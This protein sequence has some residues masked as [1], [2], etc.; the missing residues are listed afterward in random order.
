[1]NRAI[2]GII[3]STQNDKK[4]HGRNF[5]AEKALIEKN[6]Q[7]KRL[8][9]E[10]GIVADIM[11]RSYRE[12][13]WKTKNKIIR[14]IVTLSI[15]TICL[16]FYISN[17]K[18]NDVDLKI[19]YKVDD[20]FRAPIMVTYEKG[21]FGK[22][23]VDVELVPLG[24]GQEMSLAISTGK[25]DVCSKGPTNFFIPISKGAPVKVIAFQ[26]LSRS[27]LFVRPDSGIDTFKDLEGRTVCSD[28]GGSSY[29]TLRNALERENIDIS[30]ITFVDID[31]TY[32]PIA[33]MERRVVDAST[34]A[35]FEET[36]YIEA[37]AVL[38][39]EWRT[40]GY[41]NMFIPKVIIAV[42][43][44]FLADNHDKVERFIDALI[45]GH[46]FIESNPKEAAELVAKHINLGTG[47]ASDFSGEDVQK[48][49]SN[50][51][52]MLWFDPD[53]LVDMSRIAKELGDIENELTLEQI[54]DL[55]FEQK[56]KSAQADIYESKD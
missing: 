17:A 12:S 20:I 40:K 37:G 25:I 44:D 14:G 48:R 6:R 23:G 30:K 36:T 47:G 5:K 7:S 27:L 22:H 55:T 15:I 3:M 19:G 24:G 18:P 54:F 50:T 4:E 49:W 56:L 2:G 28:A 34:A 41:L 38:L 21:F 39:K 31:K 29:M 11:K 42:N 45:D 53:T 43:T 46:R 33:L 52:Y 10:D 9:K 35:D 51:N 16:V 1:M 32:R 26:V 13:E 8:K